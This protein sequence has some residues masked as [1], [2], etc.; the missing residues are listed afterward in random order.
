M[1]TRHQIYEMM[2]ERAARGVGIL[3]VSTDFDELATVS[4]RILLCAGGA[5]AGE[6]AP[7]YTATGSRVRSIPP[8]PVALPER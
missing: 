4:H 7:P 3:W 1:A 2:R 8:R 5:I 6:I